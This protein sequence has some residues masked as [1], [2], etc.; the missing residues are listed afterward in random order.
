MEA[1][2]IPEATPV[3]EAPVVAAPD[4]IPVES[5]GTLQQAEEFLEELEQQP[6][7]AAPPTGPDPDRHVFGMNY[8]LS[9]A[10]EEDSHHWEWPEGEESAQETDSSHTGPRR[11]SHRHRGWKRRTARVLVRIVIVVGIIG[12]AVFAYFGL[13]APALYAPN[14]LRDVAAEQL[15]SR[16]FNEASQTYATLADRYTPESPER[17]EALFNAAQAL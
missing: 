12:G 2:E 10:R 4:P 13:I 16:Q 3:D 15:R 9:A 7:E 1:A 11:R 14:D 17:G 5:G 8:D 6:R